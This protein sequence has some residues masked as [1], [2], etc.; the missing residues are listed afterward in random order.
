MFPKNFT[1][2]IMM[3]D[4]RDFTSAC[5]V[6]DGSGD[7]TGGASPDAEPEPQLD[8]GNGTGTEKTFSQDELNGH[9]KREV[10]KATSKT[11][12][13]AEQARTTAVEEASTAAVQAFM[14]EHGLDDKTLASLPQQPEVERNLRAEKSKRGKVEAENARLAEENSKLRGALEGV[15]SRDAVFKEAAGKARDPQD[16]WLRLKGQMSVSDDGLN[17]VLRDASGEILAD[18]AAEVAEHLPGLIQDILTSAP[19]LAVPNGSKG[20]GSQPGRTT[21][22]PAVVPDNNLETPQGAAAYLRA[23]LAGGSK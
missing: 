2:N 23:N 21:A 1:D 19:Y 20:S 14:E 13:A 7:T 11:Q 16:I 15:V 12:A 4:A 10:A 9:I 6:E 3:L 18:T 22:P 8:Q 17:P 5:S